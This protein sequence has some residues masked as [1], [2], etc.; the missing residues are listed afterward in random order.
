MFYALLMRHGTLYELRFWQLTLVPIH[1]HTHTYTH[2]HRTPYPNMFEVHTRERIFYLSA[3]THDEMQSWVGMLQTL[4]QYHQ[5]RQP[6][7]RNTLKAPPPLTGGDSSDEAQAS[8]TLVKREITPK[9]PLDTRVS[10]PPQ[11]FQHQK[12]N[13]ESSFTMEG[14]VVSE[15]LCRILLLWSTV[16]LHI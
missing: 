1:T 10:L 2:T 3:I 15:T 4:K 6:R 7:E 11:L 8:P 14:A 5:R 16:V 13:G 9:S 12:E